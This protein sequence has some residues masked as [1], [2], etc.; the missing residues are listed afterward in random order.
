M[1]PPP[2]SDIGDE[3][4]GGRLRWM[5]ERLPW[6]RK[7][8][9]KDCRAHVPSQE[10]RLPDS[11]HLRP[12]PPL[13]T[14]KVQGASC[15]PHLHCRVNGNENATNAAHEHISPDHPNMNDRRRI[16][17]PSGGTAPPLFA[18]TLSNSADQLQSSRPRRTRRADELRKICE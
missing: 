12:S 6:L 5:D 7:I 4:G 11:A 17:G 3:A 9:V 2:K 14:K 16:N 10:W 15:P 13:A 8:S 18:S 1:R